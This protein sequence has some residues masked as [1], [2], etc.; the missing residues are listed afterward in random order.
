MWMFS[1]I[2]LLNIVT[3]EIVVNPTMRWF[4]VITSMMPPL[5]PWGEVS[6]AWSCAGGTEGF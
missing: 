3:Q 6:P 5:S 4:G 1:N 2:S